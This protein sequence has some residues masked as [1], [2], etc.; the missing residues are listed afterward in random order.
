MNCYKVSSR[1]AFR[2]LSA[3]RV[4]FLGSMGSL[5]LLTRPLTHQAVPCITCPTGP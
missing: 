2:A 3:V 1:V 5:S 4:P